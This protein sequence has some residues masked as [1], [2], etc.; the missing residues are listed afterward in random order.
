MAAKNLYLPKGFT[1]DEWAA[2]INA[3]ADILKSRQIELKPVTRHQ[4]YSD[5]DVVIKVLQQF[6]AE[7]SGEKPKK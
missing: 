1:A 3:A 5:S 7:N 2:L 6:V 4:P